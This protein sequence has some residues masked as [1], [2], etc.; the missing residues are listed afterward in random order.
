MGMKPK[1]RR[2]EDLIVWPE[3]RKLNENLFKALVD[4]KMY[5]LKDHLLKTSLTTSSNIAE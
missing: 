1:I 3:S 2:L 4:S 5:F